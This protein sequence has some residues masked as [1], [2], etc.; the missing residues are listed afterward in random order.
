LGNPTRSNRQRSALNTRSQ[1]NAE[2]DVDWSIGGRIDH[3]RDPQLASPRR[4]RGDT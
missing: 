3:A 4:P 2:A 1:W